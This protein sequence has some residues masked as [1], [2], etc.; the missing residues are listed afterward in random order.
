MLRGE[1]L[2]ATDASTLHEVGGD[3]RRGHEL[4]LHIGVSEACGP[5]TKCSLTLAVEG[6]LVVRG[7]VCPKLPRHFSLVL[8]T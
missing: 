8:R 5:A 2:T 4:V 6:A 3:A 1:V 7:L